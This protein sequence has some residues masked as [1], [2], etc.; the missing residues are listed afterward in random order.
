VI[1]NKYPEQI[2][3]LIGTVLAWGVVT[4]TS[5]LTTSIGVIEPLAT[6]SVSAIALPSGGKLLSRTLWADEAIKKLSGIGFV[7]LNTRT[8][9]PIVT[10][11]VAVDHHA[12]IIGATA[13][14]V[15][16]SVVALVLG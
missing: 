11:A 8:V 10:T 12:M 5:S 4:D 2:F 3:M 14:A 1:S 7:D 15:L 6:V 13:D 9:I 16:A